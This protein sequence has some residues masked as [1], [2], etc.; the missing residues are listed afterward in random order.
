M[1][2]DIKNRNHKIY[3]FFNDSPYFIFKFTFK[4]KFTFKLISNFKIG[5]Q[6][7]VLSVASVS[8][9]SSPM[10]INLNGNF[11]MEDDEP[12]IRRY[13]HPLFPQTFHKFSYLNQPKMIC[14]MNYCD[15]EAYLNLFKL[16]ETEN[17]KLTSVTK[18]DIFKS[19]IVC[20]KISHG[21]SKSIFQYF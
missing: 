4:I 9:A 1:K 11:L 18:N 10:H 3:D 15:D 21:R 17:C 7:P 8:T 12:S 6:S 16:N 13:D 2:K 19:S 20:P 14:D 5:S